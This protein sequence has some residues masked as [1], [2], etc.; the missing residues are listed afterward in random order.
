V[1]DRPKQLRRNLIASG[2]V[3]LTGVAVLLVLGLIPLSVP[4]WCTKVAALFTFSGAMAEL[5]AV[6]KFTRRE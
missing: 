5:L 2:S 1:T 3:M 6:W 4:S